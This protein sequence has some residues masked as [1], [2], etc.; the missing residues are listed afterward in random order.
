MNSKIREPFG[1]EEENAKFNDLY[2][3]SIKKDIDNMILASN[4]RMISFLEIFCSSLLLEFN[5]R[6]PEPNYSIYMTYRIK[7]SKS[8][9]DKLSDYLSRIKTSDDN[10]SMKEFTDLIGLRV[11]IEKIPHNI[12]VDKNNPNYDEIQKLKIDRKNNISLSESFHDFAETL[13]DNSCTAFDYYSKSAELIQSILNMLNSETNPNYATRLKHTYNTLLNLC[14]DNITFLK[15]RGD[16]SSL[17]S[18]NTS[19]ISTPS[20]KRVITANG[21]DFNQLLADFDSRIDGK[22]ALALYSST[23]PSIFQKSKVLQTLGVTL[24]DNPS[25]TKRKRE[26]SGFVANFQGIN[27]KDIPINFELQFMPVDEYLASILGYSAHSN[28][29]NKDPN[30][31]ELPFAYADR[32]MTLFKNIGSSTHLDVSQIKLLRTLMKIKPLNI[33]ELSILNEIVDTLTLENSINGVDISEEKIEQLKSIC[34]L[35]EEQEATLNNKLL[36]DGVLYFNSWADNICALHATARLDKDSSA[37]NRIKIDYDGPYERLAHVMRQQIEGY[38]L[39]SSKSDLV[40]AYLGDIYKH[41]D[42][43]FESKSNTSA[44]IMNFEIENYIR[45]DLS[46]FKN[47][48][49]DNFEHSSKDSLNKAKEGR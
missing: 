16:Y 17:I 15:A 36:S 10:I 4:N 29:P 38:N 40:E 44:S 28:M 37:K 20:N 43:W 41:Q 45:N 12:S 27:F 42:E 31:C 22:L 49:K 30:P 35:T 39:D 11:I 47:Y 3:N 46:D 5:E 34:S 48:I 2:E 33:D 13:E 9:I 18:L 6:F 26:P 24:S 32:N 23:L 25:R 21:I 1:S 8:N 14:N 19:D 7:S